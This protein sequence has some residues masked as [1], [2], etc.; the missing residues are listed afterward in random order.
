MS[1]LFYREVFINLGPFLKKGHLPS[2]G[3]GDPPTAGPHPPPLPNKK[4]VFMPFSPIYLY[5]DPPFFKKTADSYKFNQKYFYIFNVL[6]YDNV[7]VLVLGAF[8]GF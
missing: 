7:M 2:S 4:R 8:V 1:I 6:F 5:F 3:L